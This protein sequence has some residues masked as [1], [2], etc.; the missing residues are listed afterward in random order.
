MRRERATDGADPLVA[1]LC[2]RALDPKHAAVA[3]LALVDH[4]LPSVVGRTPWVRLDPRA[5][6]ERQLA[7]R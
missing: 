6:G 2:G 4:E 1:L 7:L 3:A 5:C